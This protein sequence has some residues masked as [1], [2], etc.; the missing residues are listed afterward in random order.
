MTCTPLERLA[1]RGATRPGWRRGARR[2]EMSEQAK[3][4]FKY[5]VKLGGR[6]IDR[7]ITYDLVKREGQIHQEYGPSARLQQVGRRTTHEAALRWLRAGGQ[8]RYRKAQ[9]PP[10]LPQH[11]KGLPSKIKALFS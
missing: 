10:A 11:P 6:T 2:R 1:A 9:A 4:T 5:H 8:R 3:D 7:G